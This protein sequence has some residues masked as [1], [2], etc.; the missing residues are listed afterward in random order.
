[1]LFVATEREMR[2]CS[3]TGTSPSMCGHTTSS[4][5]K[6]DEMPEIGFGV[7]YLPSEAYALEETVMGGAKG[8]DDNIFLWRLW[9]QVC[10]PEATGVASAAA[11]SSPL[12]PLVPE[13][14]SNDRPVR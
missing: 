3:R 4:R 11:P 6:D 7:G 9:P 14:R 5:K 1:M 2:I 13:L 10:V 8:D 12:L